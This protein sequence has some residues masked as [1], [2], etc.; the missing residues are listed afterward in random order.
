MRSVLYYSTHPENFKLFLDLLE[1]GFFA[2]NE[3]LQES[4]RNKDNPLFIRRVKEELKDFYS[5]CITT[6]RGGNFQEWFDILLVTKAV[7]YPDTS[8]RVEMGNVG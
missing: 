7:S 1:P 4:I 8:S 6:S 3:V 2:T 5:A